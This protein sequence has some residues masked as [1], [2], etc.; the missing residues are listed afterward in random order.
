MFYILAIVCIQSVFAPAI[1]NVR[2]NSYVRRKKQK[3]MY[4]VLERKNIILT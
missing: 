1:A 2:N 3:E 4:H